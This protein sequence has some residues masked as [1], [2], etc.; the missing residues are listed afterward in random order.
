MIAHD[1]PHDKKLRN[2]FIDNPENSYTEDKR[3]LP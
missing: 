2:T 1:F 3:S